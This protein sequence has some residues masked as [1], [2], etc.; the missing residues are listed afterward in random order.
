MK[1]KPF[2]RLL[3]AMILVIMFAALVGCIANLKSRKPDATEPK[4][5]KK[6]PPLVAV[7][8]RD[9]T[10]DTGKGERDLPPP[11]GRESSPRRKDEPSGPAYE[12]PPPP[13]DPGRGSR[14]AIDLRKK[15]EVNAAAMDFA[16][17][18]KGVKHVKTCYSRLYG[19]WY[20][21]L[22]VQKEK[23]VALQQYSWNESTK[24]WDVSYYLKEVPQNQIEYHLKSEI[25]D[26]KCF[27]L[28]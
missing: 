4:V 18:I 10:L 1:M 11:P 22:Y 20:L 24:E 12:P 25:A 8:P 6:E 23:K 7:R 21:M 28:K 3:T 15:E 26:E 19:G 27:L 13:P 16:K 17:N 14:G 5:A 2:H 9:T